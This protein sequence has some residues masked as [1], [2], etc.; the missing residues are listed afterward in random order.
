MRKTIVAVLAAAAVLVVGALG[1]LAQSDG[2]AVDESAAA[3]RPGR[4]HLAGVLLDEMVT[5]GVITGDQAHAI[6]EWLETRWADRAEHRAEHRAAWQE[7][8]ADG[9]LTEVEATRFPIL[10][11]L[12]ADSEAWSDGQLTRAEFDALKAQFPLGHHLRRGPQ[13]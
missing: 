3:E 12:L 11:R 4:S 8:W 9:V 13:A 6:G 7:V 10:A 5:D 2:S 1:A